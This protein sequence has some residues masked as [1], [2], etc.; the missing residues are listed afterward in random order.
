MR[1]ITPITLT[2]SQSVP[3]P[4]PFQQMIQVPVLFRNGVR[5][6]SPTDGQ[7]YAWLESISS[8]GTATIWVKIPSSIPVNGTYQL[9]MIQ[10]STLPM[11]GVY[12]GEAP[13]LSG[14]YAQY[15]NGASIFPF[16]DNFAGTSLNTSK[17][18]VNGI[19]YNVNN[20][21]SAI[22]SAAGGDGVWT[23]SANYSPPII[24]DF[25]GN[26]Y[27]SDGVWAET[28]FVAT[29]SPYSTYNDGT[30]IQGYSGNIFGQ[31]HVNISSTNSGNLATSNVGNQIWTVIWASSTTSNYQLNYGNT[32][33]LS[34]DAP[35][36]PLAIG[37]VKANNGTSSPTYYVQW[38]RTRA[39]PPN[40]VMPSI[41]FGASQYS[42][43]L[44]TVTVP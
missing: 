22:S 39:Y 42:G 27:A 10:D 40:G 36:P 21:F 8:G 4:A 1:I 41:S 14:T 35:Y 3:T 2:N 16:Y 9:Y 18:S 32:Q 24:L 34:S 38:L 23:P 20:G 44:I 5:F 29:T 33:T 31:Q 15:D 11:D 13:Q 17:W 43:E 19:T 7:L 37:L 30:F 25:Y 28:G 26:P 6:W 12:W